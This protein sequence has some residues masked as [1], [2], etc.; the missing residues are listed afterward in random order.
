M[1]P[2]I[3]TLLVLANL[4]L[5]G[6]ANIKQSEDMLQKKDS[7]CKSVAEFQFDKIAADATNRFKLDDLNPVYAFPDGKSYFKAYSVPASMANLTLNLKIYEQGLRAISA[8]QKPLVFCPTLLFLDGDMKTVAEVT[9]PISSK[10]LEI[11]DLSNWR[12]SIVIPGGTANL[13]IYTK[14]RNLGSVNLLPIWKSENEEVKN[15][16]VLCGPAGDFELEVI[17]PNKPPKPDLTKGRGA[18][19]EQ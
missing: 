4:F 13:V 9:P 18:G 7:C 15:I 6:C 8:V 17:D 12:T 10:S 16:E 5:F 2:R 3:L 14:A 11:L 1:H 19:S